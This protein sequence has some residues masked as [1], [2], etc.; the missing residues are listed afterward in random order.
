MSKVTYFS[1]EHVSPGH[2]DKICDFI[3][4]SVLDYLLEV[5]NKA[6]RVA[7]DGVIK[8]N[9]VHLVGEITAA[10]QVPF[11]TLVRRAI[12]SIGYTKEVSPSF[13]DESVVV[14]TDFTMQ[15]PDIAMGVDVK[16]A[17]DIG[18]MFG[19]AVNEAPDLT[20]WAHY[21]ARYLSYFVY[22]HKFA[23][24]KPDQKTQVTIKYV[25]GEPSA[26]ADIVV[27]ISHDSTKSLIEIR[28]EVEELVADLL[29][30]IPF[31]EGFDYTNYKLHVNPT[32][33]FSVFGPVADSGEVGRK[34]VC[35][36]YGGFF[37][38]GGGNLNGKDA[39]KVDRSAVYMARCAAKSVVARGL[40]SKCQIQV[41]YAIGEEK[42]ISIKVDTFG[43][44]K[45][46]LDE[47]EEFVNK[48]FDFT[49][50]G[51]IRTFNLSSRYSDRKFSYKDLGAYGH[52]G[53]SFYGEE[54]PWEKTV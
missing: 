27:C 46:T 2:P 47:I 1:A 54:K 12:S 17:G 3:A 14:D 34:I 4:E 18:I 8:N 29:K 39:T 50:Q 23:W 9:K 16:G 40:A 7:V 5:E 13:N 19:G 22:K 42:P 32:G 6:P 37:A 49:P 35:D 36:Q 28:S 38:V 41:A 31:P 44:E 33:A 45:V 11:D 48:S 30:D 21:L 52:I 25:D 24:A 20:S 53:E 43:T 26:I 10:H 51:I 15:S